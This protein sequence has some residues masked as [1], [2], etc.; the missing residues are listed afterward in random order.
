M[1]LRCRARSVCPAHSVWLGP[2]ACRG[3]PAPCRSAWP[4]VLG[5]SVVSGA[6]ICVR[7]PQE[8]HRGPHGAGFFLPSQA[9]APEPLAVRLVARAGGSASARTTSCGGPCRVGGFRPLQRNEG[10]G[11]LRAGVAVLKSLTCSCPQRPQSPDRKALDPPPSLP[12]SSS[13]GQGP[14]HETRPASDSG[15]PAKAHRGSGDL[16]RVVSYGPDPTRVHVMQQL[17]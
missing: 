14:P 1:R 4:R 12:A 9:R 5:N 6:P 16:K 10:R 17:F 2:Q 11:V 8:G 15:Q 13:P 7:G 3:V